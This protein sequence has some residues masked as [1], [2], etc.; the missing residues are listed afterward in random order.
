MTFTWAPAWAEPRSPGSHLYLCGTTWATPTGREMRMVA[1]PL[2][3]VTAT[4]GPPSASSPTGSSVVAGFDGH[5]RGSSL[6]SMYR[7]KGT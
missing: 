6:R 7:G 5:P 4:A 1:T 2:V 3:S